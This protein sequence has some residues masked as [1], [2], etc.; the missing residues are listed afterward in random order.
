MKED[1][2]NEDTEK[3]DMI[4]S[5]DNLSDVNNKYR[6]RNHLRRRDNSY[7][8]N[9]NKNNTMNTRR[10]D[11]NRNRRGFLTYS[12]FFFEPPPSLL[13]VEKNQ[14]PPLSLQVV[15]D[16]K[17]NSW[18][19]DKPIETKNYQELELISII[20]DEIMT[21]IKQD[22]SYCYYYFYDKS[23]DLEDSLN[24]SKR[25]SE[26]TI[27][28]V[29]CDYV[30]YTLWTM[31]MGIF[32]RASCRGGVDDD[33]IWK[34]RKNINEAILKLGTNDILKDLHEKP[35]FLVRRDWYFKMEVPLV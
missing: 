18:K 2:E 24:I 32:T 8:R 31:L 35:F 7:R 15:S 23:F 14:F 9:D 20:C 5:R 17:K 11:W 27:M 16:D 12:E 19:K 1:T 25:Q 10:N 30:G 4:F 33:T 13:E 28:D 29:Q 3:E 26:I 22:D 34:A 6:G 21:I